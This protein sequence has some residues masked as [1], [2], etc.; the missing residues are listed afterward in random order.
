MSDQ[1]KRGLGD[2]SLNDIDYVDGQSFIMNSLS[3]AV[4]LLVKLAKRNHKVNRHLKSS[5]YAKNNLQRG[6]HLNGA[7]QTQQKTITELQDFDKIITA[8]NNREDIH[9]G[10]NK[11]HKLELCSQTGNFGNH[12]ANNAGGKAFERVIDEAIK[13]A[14]VTDNE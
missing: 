14:E 7:L 10:V 3:E 8:I 4:K 12:I 11:Q 5:I 6:V 9:S 2:N 1:K 13:D